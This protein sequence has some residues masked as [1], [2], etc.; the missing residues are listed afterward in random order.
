MTPLLRLRFQLFRTAQV[1]VVPTA[2][3]YYEAEDGL[4][5]GS[6]PNM[7]IKHALRT[8]RVRGSWH[9]FTESGEFE[10]LRERCAKPVGPRS[11]A[12]LSM[13]RETEV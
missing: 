3:F 5:P 2:M 7:L 12:G 4:S 8:L 13:F 1:L 10:R 11:E 9:R 6:L